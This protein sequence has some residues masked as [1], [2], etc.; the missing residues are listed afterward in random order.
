MTGRLDLRL[1]VVALA[2]WLGAACGLGLS[3]RRAVVVSAVLLSGATLAGLRRSGPVGRMIVAAALTGGLAVLVGSWHIAAARPHL[4]QEL[5]ARHAD[6]AIEAVARADARRLPPRAGRPLGRPS[7]ALTVEL[8]RIDAGARP[9]RLRAAAVVFSA[10]AGW[11]QL[12]TG[13]RI[14]FRATLTPAP[15]GDLAA[16]LLARSPPVRLGATAPV[17]RAGAAVRERLRRSTAVL[18]AADGG[19]LSGLVDGDTERLPA[20]VK[21]E[22]RATGL[23]HLVAVSGANLA[24]VIGAVVA[25]VRRLGGSRRVATMLG[26]PALFGFLVV[27]GPQPSVLRAAGMALVLLAGELSGRPHRALPA[28]SG[29]VLFLVLVD[30]GLAREPG[31]LLSVSATAGLLLAHRPL[32]DRLGRRLPR[33]VADL[34]AVPLAAQLACTPALVALFGRVSLVAVP[35]NVVAAPLVLPA[36]VLG[37]LAAALGPVSL[38]AGQLLARLA[39][40]CTALLLWVA[41]IGAGLPGG[42]FGWPAGMAGAALLALLGLGLAVGLRGRVL[43]PALVTAALA[44][45]GSGYAVRATTGWPPP[46]WGVVVCDV[47]QGDAVVL[48]AGGDS[49]VLVDAGPD[50]GKVDRCLR[51]AG[52][53]RLPLV[54]LTHLHAD[55]VEGLPG[56]LRGR[57]VG[58]VQVGPLDEPPGEL[59]RVRRW[60]A[61]R[62]IALLRPGSAERRLAGSLSW[63][64]LAPA[65]AFQGTP[66]DPNN[67]SLVLRAEIAGLRVLLTG[68]VELAAQSELLGSGVD[69]SADV[70]KVPHHGSNRQVPELLDRVGERVAVTSVGAGNDYGHPAPSTVRRLADSG[71]RGLRTDQD[72]SVA[73]LRRGGTVLAVG[74]SGTGTPPTGQQMVAGQPG[75]PADFRL[76]V[77]PTAAG[78]L[79]RS[80]APV[81]MRCCP[82]E[83]PARRSTGDVGPRPGG[84]AGRARGP[85]AAGRRP[86]G[87]RRRGGCRPGRRH[88]RCRRARRAALP[89]P[90]R[91]LAVGRAA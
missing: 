67:S 13:D 76:A 66:S 59:N 57:A 79:A 21:A 22:F 64:V 83:F 65:R 87:R 56:A 4:V 31:L 90:V 88:P 53:R 14:G 12:R 77:N 81:A 73:L 3:G 30:P 34:L 78:G 27:A 33:L 38:A 41:H 36:T 82:G 55:H 47:G 70:L 8:R 51:S 60:L 61:P 1:A 45:I 29:A 7:V 37:F 32:A 84:A 20:E 91:R 72:G 39:R 42:S 63:Q 24:I 49:G 40:P 26:V 43:R 58:G 44:A 19:L 46:D 17:A 10:A 15:D 69:L 6:A 28:L 50:P 9:V 62:G 89:G 18:P 35:A 25:V 23:T 54:V 48:R 2:A 52:V 75:G 68:D 85:P 74:Q 5:G 86:R 11:G 80:V 16:V 71:A